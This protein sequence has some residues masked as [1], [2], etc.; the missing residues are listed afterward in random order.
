[1]PHRQAHDDRPKPGEGAVIYK[2]GLTPWSYTEALDNEII[3]GVCTLYFESVRRD[4]NNARM[5]WFGATKFRV[6]GMNPT[7]AA[8][9][10][11]I[12][13]AISPA[14]TNFAWAIFVKE[15]REPQKLPGQPKYDRIYN[16]FIPC[17]TSRNGGS[18]LKTIIPFARYHLNWG[19]PDGWGIGQIDRSGDNPPSKTETEEAW[20][21]KANIRSANVKLNEKLTLHNTLVGYFEADYGTESYWVNLPATHTINNT[22][23]TSAQWATI[24]LYNGAQGVT[25]SERRYL[26]NTQGKPVEF[27]S[28]WK[29]NLPKPPATKGYWTFHDNKKNYAKEVRLI[30]ENTPALHLKTND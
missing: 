27:Q 19:Q 4:P 17:D 24:V 28:P 30:L 2:K 1:M 15:T 23:L 11:Y 12:A 10:N 13:E 18:D 8:V 29:F 22:T 9:T 21:W 16:Q 20:D 5:D 25:K 3:G 6:R 7:D 14:Y 26:L